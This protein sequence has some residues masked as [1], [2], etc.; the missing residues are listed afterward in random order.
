MRPEA[1]PS[2][3][4]GQMRATLGVKPWAHRSRCSG[5][6]IVGCPVQIWVS[7]LALV[8]EIQ[9]HLVQ[10]LSPLQCS[11]RFN[12]CRRFLP[13]AG[14]SARRGGTDI[15][16]KA[17]LPG[18]RRCLAAPKIGA[19]SSSPKAFKARLVLSL[20]DSGSSPVRSVGSAATETL[21][22]PLDPEATSKIPRLRGIGTL[23]VP[24][25]FART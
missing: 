19:G 8:T 22:S 13:T 24:G 15:N 16:G 6:L 18:R 11:R 14:S 5:V 2:K 1:R 4:S 10:R 23:G 21:D 3:S 9:P 20:C 25:T 17:E 12:T 7:S